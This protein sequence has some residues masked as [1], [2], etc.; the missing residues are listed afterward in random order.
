MHAQKAINRDSAEV[1]KHEVSFN[2]VVPT[3]K[4]LELAAS[5]GKIRVVAPL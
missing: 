2:L 5:V 3:K 4:T 1:T